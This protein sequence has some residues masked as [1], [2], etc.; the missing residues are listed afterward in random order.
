M[1]FFKVLTVLIC[2]TILFSACSSKE[3][4]T[5]T[6]TENNVIP[7]SVEQVKK[8]DISTSFRYSG[9][10]KTNKEVMVVSKVSGRVKEIFFRVGDDV[11][12]GDILFTVDDKDIQ[13]SIKSLELQ[14]KSAQIAVNM[15]EKALVAS[16][17]S[18]LQQQLTQAETSLKTSELQYNDAKKNFEDIKLLYEAGSVSQQQYQQTKTAYETAQISFNA[19]KQSYDL[20]VNKTSK[21]NIDRAKDQLNQSIASKENVEFQLKKAKENLAETKVK[22]PINGVV[23]SRTIEEGEMIGGSS[24]P[25]VVVQI[26]P[27]V[28]AVNV[29]EQMLGS[30]KEGD[31]VNIAVGSIKDKSFLGKIRSIAP[32]ADERAATYPVEI[33]IENNN[34]ELKAGMFGEVEFITNK[35]ENT[36]VVNRETIVEK[37]QK[38]YIFTATKDNKS[39]LV[40]V[41][42]GID[43][44]KE[45]EITKGLEIGQTIIVKGQDYLVDGNSIKITE[46]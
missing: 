20:L 1:K 19:A 25:F 17:G 3:D 44:G 21:E 12:K 5:K 28:F 2:T 14:L 10:I 35:K 24:V 29:S 16:K 26:N 45:I 13:D 41:Q 23:S 27:A 8:G 42:I 43:N 11:K 40:E 37:N 33:E 6:P 18:Q 46:E 22:S 31:S 38:S 30:I 39:K 15:A 36:I 32:V 34:N 4:E 7:V 9:T